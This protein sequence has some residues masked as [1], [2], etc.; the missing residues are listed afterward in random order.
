MWL[1]SEMEKGTFLEYWD[2][3]RMLL[4]LRLVQDSMEVLQVLKAAL[5]A[6]QLKPVKDAS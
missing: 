3:D 2:K 4:Q 6:A 5:N 1:V